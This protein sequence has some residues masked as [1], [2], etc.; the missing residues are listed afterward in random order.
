VVAGRRAV[1]HATADV[2]RRAGRALAGAAG[3]LLAERLAATASHLAAGLGVVGALARRGELGDDDLVHQRDVDLDLEHLCRQ[4]DGPDLLAGRGEDVDGA[5]LPAPFCGVLEAVRT[6]TRLP[7]GPGTAPLISTRPFS[8]STACTVRL[9]VV[10]RTW[11]IRP[12]IRTPLNTRAGVAQAPIA[13]GERCLRWVPCALPSPAK[14]CR[15]IT[16]AVPL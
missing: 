13:P 12:A 16:P 14:P 11:P 10:V 6:S 1:D 7:R 5:H 2:L 8:A 4:L 9:N 15:F 3:A